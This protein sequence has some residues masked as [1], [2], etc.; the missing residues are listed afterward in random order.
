MVHPA[1]RNRMDFCLLGFMEIVVL[2]EVGGRSVG[3][4]NRLPLAVGF[5]EG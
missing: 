1:E 4:R 5:A 2:C 3:A